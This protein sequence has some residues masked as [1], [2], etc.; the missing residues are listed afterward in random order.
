MPS[1]NV[2]RDNY[3]NLAQSTYGDRA[4]IGI[5]D[6]SNNLIYAMFALPGTSNNVSSWQIKQLNYT[7]TNLI[8]I[9]WPQDVNGKASTA[10]SF[11]PTNYLTYTY[12]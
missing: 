5:Y 1:P 8:N 6:G 9:K 4:F 12:S 7:D 3:F 10:Y 2:Q 11:N